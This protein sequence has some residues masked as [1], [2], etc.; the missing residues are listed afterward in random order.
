MS[1]KKCVIIGIVFIFLTAIVYCF[2]NLGNYLVVK[3]NLEKAD[4]IVV[5]SGDNGPRTEMG[6][7][8]LKKGY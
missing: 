8:L 7:D 1:R 5:F 2:F 6:V 4:A 3:D